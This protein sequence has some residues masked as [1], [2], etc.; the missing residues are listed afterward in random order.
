MH[1]E[2]VILLLLLLLADALGLETLVL[3]RQ[4]AD[5]RVIIAAEPVQR[6]RQ[7][8]RKQLRAQMQLVEPAAAPAIARAIAEQYFDAATVLSRML[9]DLG[10]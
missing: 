2:G 8:A 4:R 10:L 6:L 3:L 7:L 9:R 1:P 5:D